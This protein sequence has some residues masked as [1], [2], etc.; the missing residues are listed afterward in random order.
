M[1]YVL[2]FGFVLTILISCTL[3]IINS[4]GETKHNN[5]SAVL[6]DSGENSS[7]Y[8]QVDEIS[9]VEQNSSDGEVNHYGYVTLTTAHERLLYTR[10]GQSV[11]NISK[12]KDE[13]GHFST[14][15]IRISGEHM[16]E[17]SIRHSLNA[18]LSDNP[19]VFWLENLFGYAYADDDTIVECYSVM[20]AEECSEKV[21]ILSD[22][23][24]SILD[25]IKVS[26]TPYD[27]EKYIH[28]TILSSCS[29]KEGVTSMA[30]GW[31]YFSVYGAVVEGEAVC[32]GYAKSMQLLLNMAGVPCYTIRGTADGV[33]HLWNVVNVRDDWYHLDPTWDDSDD[34]LNY[35]YFNVTTA[36]ISKNHIIA[37]GMVY[38]SETN[39]EQTESRNFF[40]PDCTSTIM[41]YYHIEGFKLTG[42]SAEENEQMIGFLVRRA[43]KGDS[44]IPVCI[45]ESLDY[46]ECVEKL[47]YSF[48]YKFYYY[49][50]AANERLSGNQKIDRNS[51]KI[52]KNEENM[53]LRIKLNYIDR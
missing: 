39:A 45:S 38:M 1:L 2:F 13:N 7:V 29:Y 16:T 42:F 41:N 50:D 18:Y 51:I 36:E 24:D 3:L 25:N 19:Q 46:N 34:N 12:E 32:E 8:K 21:G 9:A 5:I 26:M 40:V 52:L 35:E 20:S 27:C 4:I 31:Q 10:I 22:R 11:H 53:T 33:E 48:P 17:E 30:D 49:I 23:I 15:R 47:F 14:E 44:Y 28:D 6:I 43:E 37:P